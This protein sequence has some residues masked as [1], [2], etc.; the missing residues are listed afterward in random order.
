MGK[1][2]VVILDTAA[3]RVAEIALYIEGEGFPVAAKK[4]VDQAFEFFETLSNEMITHRPCKYALWAILNYRCA[5][6]RK[7]YVV[8]Y[9]NLSEE[10]IICN[11]EIQKKLI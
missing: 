6:F 9:L 4:F 5:N 10:I 3:V 1:R 8:A 7:K 11:F 2:K